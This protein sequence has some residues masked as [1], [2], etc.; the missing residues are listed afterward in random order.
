[1]AYKFY[2][3]LSILE[4]VEQEQ[5]HI[6]KQKLFVGMVAASWYTVNY[7]KISF[8]KQDQLHDKVAEIALLEGI[9][10]DEDRKQIKKRLNESDSLATNKLLQH[11][12]QQVPHRFLSP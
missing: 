10:I 9:S 12:N 4:E 5:Y 6:P 8:G 7:F 11:F 2:W 1:M 3:F